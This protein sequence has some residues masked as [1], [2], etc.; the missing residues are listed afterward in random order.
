ML[1]IFDSGQRS[2]PLVGIGTGDIFAW[3]CSE[4]RRGC[5]PGKLSFQGAVRLKVA[6]E[7][8]RVNAIESAQ[9]KMGVSDGVGVNRA[10]Q[11]AGVSAD[12]LQ[13]AG[14]RHSSVSHRR[15]SLLKGG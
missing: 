6:I 11:Q 12:R 10:V 1:R 15:C 14:Y 7:R 4:R 3:F 5:R 13:N 8:E 9:V 2:G